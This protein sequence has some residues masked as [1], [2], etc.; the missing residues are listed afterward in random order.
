[1]VNLKNGNEPYEARYLG[2]YKRM[3][4]R[5]SRRRAGAGQ[6]SG[7]V[8]CA[9][10][11][12]NGGSFM[13]SCGPSARLYPPLRTGGGFFGLTPVEASGSQAP[14]CVLPRLRIRRLKEIRSRVLTDIPKMLAYVSGDLFDDY[15][16]DM[17]ITQ[18][19]AS[20][21]RK[22]MADV[23]M[24]SLGIHDID[25]QFTT[26]HNY[27]GTGRMILRMT[28]ENRWKGYTPHA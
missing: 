25:E 20:L 14:G 15:I 7:A 9:A 19:F 6:R 23:I 16:H 26:V 12:S 22:A 17:K 8:S 18:H 13:G 1:M 10:L 11:Y 24:R 28:I 3:R 27:I 4:L 21:N 5:M 2:E